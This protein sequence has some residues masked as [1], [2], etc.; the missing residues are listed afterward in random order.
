M[1]K[2]G[3]GCAGGIWGDGSSCGETRPPPPPF[4][5]GNHDRKI[6]PTSR[7]T[8]RPKTKP[9]RTS[10]FNN[11]FVSLLPMGSHNLHIAIESKHLDYGI[12]KSTNA[13]NTQAFTRENHE[14]V[15]DRAL[16]LQCI[17][18]GSIGLQAPTR[19]PRRQRDRRRAD[20]YHRRGRSDHR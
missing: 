3:R 2:K 1:K 16:R 5:E 4:S 10:P 12:R 20:S 8:T 19:T 17:I 11:M 18:L 7:T 13:Y 14:D 15:P 6:S 9:Q